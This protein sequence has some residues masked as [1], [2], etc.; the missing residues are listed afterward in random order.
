[1]TS[2]FSGKFLLPLII[3]MWIPASGL[4]AQQA[5]TGYQPKTRL[6]FIMD[7]S[8]SMAGQWEGGRKFDI[9]RNILMDMVDSLEG[10]PNVE[11]ALRIYGH[12]SPVPPQDC[13][14]TKLEVPFS[15][16][17]AARIRQK[18]KVINPKGTTPIAHSLEVSPGDFPP[19][20]NC[21]NIILLITDG[22]EACDGDPCEVSR[23]LQKEGIILRPF[24]I[25]IGNDPGFRETFHC[26]GEYYDAPGREQFREA[27][28]VVI[29]QA[30]N[31]TSAQ[32]NLLDA[33]RRPTE[34]DVNMVFYDTF[35]GA[36]RY[37]M[38]HTLNGRGN[39]DTLSLDHLS[40]YR[41][42]AQTIPPVS[43]DRWDL[44]TGRHN[45]IG[46]DAPQG[47]LVVKTG[48][49]ESYDNEKILVKKAGEP[50][51]I[52]VQKMGQTS[53]YIAGKYDLEIPI[54]PLMIVKDVE[55]RQSYTTTVE[56]PVPGLVTFKSPQPGAGALYQLTPGGDQLWVLNLGE[57][58]AT[59]AYYLQPGSYRVVFRRSDRKSASDSQI[60]EFKVNSG[61]SETIEFR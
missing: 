21:R 60:R 1:M 6:L 12:Q 34:T 4:H 30:L 38:I 43:A 51:T 41:V 50:A 35:S 7:A 36:I 19:C 53:R 54:Y 17:N 18:L 44:V 57:Q 24:V 29:T 2:Q 8:N 14:D 22:I 55:I 46:I 20:S 23:Q 56:I 45:T 42:V 33:D 58:T 27:L 5:T 39:P 28:R 40:T 47:H 10:N 16:N 59:Q 31:E 26:I 11:M 61:S 49:G 15:P 37:N 52:N 48:R 9:A 32:V 25:G 3:S 13:N